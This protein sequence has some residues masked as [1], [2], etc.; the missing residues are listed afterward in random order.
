M[1][2]YYLC[3]WIRAPSN[4]NIEVCICYKSKA[5]LSALFRPEI[6][7]SLSNSTIIPPYRKVIFA[8]ESKL[9]ICKDI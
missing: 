5:Q 9:F 2:F 7:N 6:Y 3:T 4:K 8:L 1:K